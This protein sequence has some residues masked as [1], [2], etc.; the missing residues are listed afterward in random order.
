ML[1]TSHAQYCKRQCTALVV[2]RSKPA[3]GRRQNN[4]PCS[5]RSA[6]FR[7]IICFDKGPLYPR[8][9]FAQI[10]RLLRAEICHSPGSVVHAASPRCLILSGWASP[11]LKTGVLPYYRL[12]ASSSG[13]LADLCYRSL[14]IQRCV[15]AACTGCSGRKQCPCG[16]VHKGLPVDACSRHSGFYDV[17]ATC[18]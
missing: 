11:A 7:L 4:S 3:K 15:Q 9:Q 17:I 5:G 13:L 18:V 6:R 12:N 14:Q 1:A 2:N 16:W 10:W 8:L